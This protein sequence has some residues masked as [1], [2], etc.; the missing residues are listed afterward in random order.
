L[1]DRYSCAIKALLRLYQGA[2]KAL[3]RLYQGAAA[4]LAHVGRGKKKQQSARAKKQ[5]FLLIFS[6]HQQSACCCLTAPEHIFVSIIQY[7]YKC[8]YKSALTAPQQQR[9]NTY[10]SII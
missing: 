2:F 8:V 5:V 6:K 4:E 3:L 9:L 1:R 7:I 10:I